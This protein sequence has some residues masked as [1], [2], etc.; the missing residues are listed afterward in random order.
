MFKTILFSF[1]SI[2]SLSAQVSIVSEQSKQIDKDSIS[3]KDNTHQF[4]LKQLI[5]PSVLI[6]YGVVGIES[7]QLKLFNTQIR[8]EVKEDID[9]KLTIDDFSQYAPV[10]SVYGLN[11][12]GIKGKHNFK[13]RSIIMGTSYLIMSASVLSLKSITK[14]ERPDGS[15]FNSFPSGHTATAFAGAEF[16]WQEY[17]DVSVWYGISGYLV[18][19]GTGMFR[20]YNNKHWL[21]D[22]AAGAGIGILSTKIAYWINPWI[23]KKIF[24]SKEKNSMSA[25]APFY[26]GKQ[27][28][29]GF[30]KTF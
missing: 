6:G 3:K 28:G 19:T 7:D 29:I 24:N 21:T 20:I 16:L 9:E 13:D 17:K 27:L 10:L 8:D 5:I 23:Q 15:G 4:K 26:N 25:I 12:L 1:L 11:A 2:T 18:A 30:M 14:V 22:V